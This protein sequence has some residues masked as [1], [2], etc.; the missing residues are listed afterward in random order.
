MRITT[1]ML[2]LTVKSNLN[3]LRTRIDRLNT[4]WV[5]GVTVRQASE[6]PSEAA[7]TMRFAHA[8]DQ[9][10]RYR[11]TL[12]QTKAW[13]ADTDSA[14]GQLGDTLQRARVLILEAFNDPNPAE[15]LAAIS[16][17]I[18]QLQHHIVTIGNSQHQTSYIFGG[19]RTD[20]AP[21]GLDA[22]GNG[23]FYGNSEAMERELAFGQLVQINYVE[24]RLDIIGMLDNFRDIIDGLRNDPDNFS[25]IGQPY[26]EQLDVH[27]DVVL[28][29]RAEVGSKI[30]RVEM[31]ESRFID[32]MVNLEALVTDTIGTDMEKTAIEMAMFETAYQGALAVAGRILPM[33]LVDYLR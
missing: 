26:L 19:T 9:G 31:L 11:S 17:E 23:Q 30:N 25:T 1:Q 24:D 28:A 6:G 3:N 16:Q 7:K 13:L 27:F 4:D 5:T 2:A 21:Y 8:L 33:T 22:A 29:A 15:A 14:L 10:E 12:S 32:A 20:V 18:E